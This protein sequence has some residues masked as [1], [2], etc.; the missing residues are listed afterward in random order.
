MAWFRGVSAAILLL[1][2]N[3][4]ST[5]DTATSATSDQPGEHALRES[6]ETRQ[7]DTLIGDPGDAT[8]DEL[9]AVSNLVAAY[10]PGNDVPMDK[11]FTADAMFDTGVR[12]VWEGRDQIAEK[13]AISASSWTIREVGGFTRVDDNLLFNWILIA[14]GGD[15]YNQGLEARFQEGLISLLDASSARFG[16]CLQGFTSMRKCRDYQT[17]EVIL[18]E[19]FD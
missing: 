19:D 8:E 7:F 2:L 14:P 17:G 5:A 1:L 16:Y 6:A 11:V 12:G 3:A 10:V 15:V 18:Y 13:I 9:R 4:C